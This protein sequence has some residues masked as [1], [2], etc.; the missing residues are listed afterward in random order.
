MELKKK[1]K[2]NDIKKVGATIKD[3]A[4]LAEVSLSTV[5]RALRFPEKTPSETVQKVRQAAKELCY[6]YNA[7][8]SSLSARRA[9]TLGVIVPSPVYSAFSVNLVAIQE[10]CTEHN[11]S[12]RV[13]SSHFSPEEEHKALRRF[14]EQR[15]DGIILAGVDK[16]NIDYVKRLEDSGI[17]CIVLWEEVPDLNYIAIDNE[18]AGY[19]GVRYLLEL[20]HERIAFLV[21]PCE[22]ASRN[23][24]RYIG[25]AKALKDA[26][27]PEDPA[28]VSFSAPSF[29]LGKEHMRAL[30]KLATPPTAVLCAND[31]L[32]IGACRAILEA[33]LEVPR[34][35]SVCGFDD[36]EVSAY[37][38]PP[39]TSIKTPGYEMAR[40]ATSKIIESLLSQQQLEVRYFLDTEL[41]VRAS[42]GCRNL[43]MPQETEHAP[44]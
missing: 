41:V 12:C 43:R 11:Y 15:V 7:Q 18:K 39:L 29:L 8:A 23:Y 22:C 34:D 14:H 42:C 38:N 26:G 19:S 5:S 32:A 33:G 10:V 35:I 4:R 17:P 40:M 3:V 24:M 25:Y 2:K 9:N 30:L 1:N 6:V 21:G 36:I 13:A 37:F 31:Y 16:S 20:G 44:L 27:I 28:L